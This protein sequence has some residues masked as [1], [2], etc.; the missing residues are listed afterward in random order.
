MSINLTDEL[1]AA[2]KKGKIAAAKQVFLEGDSQN[3]QKEIEDINARHDTLSSKH[4]EL[5][6][7]VSEHTTQIA[8]NQSQIAD[9]KSA[10]DAK[11]ASLDNNMA[12]L[13]TRDDQITELVKGVTA[14]GGASVAT[15]VSYDNTSSNLDAATAQGAID[16]LTT[17]K[18][19]KTNIVQELGDAEDKVVSQKAVTDKINDI[20]EKE[21]QTNLQTILL[22]N[23]VKILNN[24]AIYGNVVASTSETTKILSSHFRRGGI[25]KLSITITNIK[26][27]DATQ[28]INVVLRKSE[29][30][31]ISLFFN[32]KEDTSLLYFCNEPHDSLYIN[33]Y[34][35]TCDV[36]LDVEDVSGIFSIY[37][38][39]NSELAKDYNSGLL[40]LFYLNSIDAFLHATYGINKEKPNKYE[41]LFSRDFEYAPI[42]QDG[43]TVGIFKTTNL[44]DFQ[45]SFSQYKDFT[46]NQNLIKL[47]QNDA[48]AR[49]PNNY[50]LGSI[51]QAPEN[52]QKETCVSLE[53][54][55]MN[56]HIGGIQRLKV[57]K[58]KKYF[59]QGYYIT[60]TEGVAVVAFFEDVLFNK[61]TILITQEPKTYL[62]YS[63]VIE[64][65]GEYLY[66]PD[67]IDVYSLTENIIKVD[68]E[69]NEKSNN[70]ISNS[71][72]TRSINALRESITG[73]NEKAAVL[74]IA[75]SNAPDYAKNNANLVCAGEND[76]QIINKAISMLP[77]KGGEI[78][79]SAGLFNVSSPIIIDRRIKIEGEGHSIGGI[80]GY[81]QTNGVDYNNN[82]WG[83]NTQNL[84]RTNGG[85]TIIRACADCHV[86]QIGSIVK[87]KLQI[88]LR[89]FTIQGYGK[90][91]HTKCGI[92]GKSSTDISVI[93]NVSIND[94]FLGCYLHGDSQNSYNDAIKIINS[95]FQ[96]CAM[97]LVAYGYWGNLI[98]CCIADNNGI[99]SYTDDDGNTTNIN[100]G[101]IFLGGGAWLASN[102]II[103]R[104]VSYKLSESKAGDAVVIKA[105]LT[106]FVNNMLSQNAGA[107][108]RIEKDYVWI[109]NNLIQNWAKSNI[110]GDMAAIKQSDDW[111]NLC[112]IQNNMFC[113]PENQLSEKDYVINLTSGDFHVVKN[114]NF[115][116]IG[117]DFKR[118][119]KSPDAIKSGNLAYGYDSE[120]TFYKEELD[121]K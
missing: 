74:T 11:N 104:S 6:T 26:K 67:S 102:N 14:T 29:D 2:T 65:K 58:G 48:N 98:N 33:S 53:G 108:I 35:C 118:Y 4:D 44:P 66:I 111:S 78:H 16:E 62:N 100:C 113:N 22:N 112:I 10:Q 93:D 7:T 120:N 72:A 21:N 32:I 99:V 43:Y 8:N 116:S 83:L 79:L 37:C 91:R 13:N 25:Y 39:E 36:E 117:K 88:A 51:I 92:Y 45:E 82:I 94:C 89:D 50:I 28:D 105:H 64:A 5:D 76:E 121:V 42:T 41:V 46:I 1:N 24:E 109:E 9:N 30:T 23:S 47:Q 49:I 107:M 96:W 81:I 69:L 106:H 12:K 70:A 80:P 19:N 20:S 90:D 63:Q 55:F 56:G 31:S 71:A 101:G 38:D 75:A 114:N 15:A 68:N 87:Q 59:I 54:K 17:K 77:A 84:Y 85:G 34:N 27:N 60:F 18:L 3:V 115:V 119:I 52:N 103:V 95:S 86:I 61:P 97:G 40:K 73:T 110:S 57:E